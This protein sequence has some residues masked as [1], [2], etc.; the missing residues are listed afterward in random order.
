MSKST[1]TPELLEAI[2]ARVPEG[3]LSRSK[4][5]RKYKLTSKDQIETLTNGSVVNVENNLFYDT[6]RLDAEQVKSLNDW[7]RP[8][9]PLLD[10][11]TH[12]NGATIAERRSA[13]QDWINQ[14]VNAQVPALFAALT[15]QQGYFPVDEASSLFGEALIGYLLQTQWLSQYQSLIYDPLS[16][17]ESTIQ[18]VEH[19]YQLMPLYNELTHYLEQKKGMTASYDELSQKFDED[20]LN[21]VLNMGGMDQF[22]VPL[23]VKPYRS[24]WIYLTLT[25][26]Q[27]AQTV[28]RA[29]VKIKDDAWADALEHSGDVVRPGARDGKT[30]RI[31]VVARTY[32]LNNAAQRLGIGTST[33]E[34]A[35]KRG[36]LSSFIDPEERV[37]IPASEIERA[38]DNP[39]A[40]EQ[41]RG[42]EKVKPREIALVAGISYSTVRRRLQRA[43]IKASGLRWE[44]VR[45]RWGLPERLDEFR[46]ILDDRLTEQRVLRDATR[47]EQERIEAERRER[48]RIAAEQENARRNELRARLVAAFPTWQHENRTYQQIVLHVG[49]PNSGKTHDA[50]NRLS[51]AEDGWYLAPLRLLA[52]EVF[53]RLNR[54]GVLCNLLTGEE[55][56]EIPGA[57]ITAATIEMFNPQNSGECVIIDEAQMLADPD[58]GWAWTRALMEA[59]AP[60]IHVIGPATAQQLI[61]DMAA[62][63]AIPL[64]AV[65]HERLTPIQVAEHNWPLNQL[66]ERTILVAFSRR[67][68][69]GL[70]TE[71]EQQGR[72]VSVV[73]GNLPPEV[74]RRQADRFADGETEICI[75]TDAVGMGLNLPADYVCFYEMQKFDGKQVR[76]LKPSEV[77]Q[78]GGRAGRYGLSTVGEVGAT[79]KRDLHLL[80]KLFYSEPATLTKARVAP[81]VNDLEM[82]PGSLASRLKQWAAL[83]SIPDTLRKVI[84]TSD[85][86]ERIELANMLT[87][88]EVRQLGLEQA[89]RLVNAPTRQSTRPYWRL[90]AQS[91]LNDRAMPLPP[92]PPDKILT[93][94]DLEDSEHSI[95][96][97]DIYLW[98]SQRPEFEAYAPDEPAVREIREEWSRTIDLALLRRL[99]TSRRCSQCGEPLPMNFPYGICDNCH[100]GRTA[101]R[102]SDY[103]DL[104]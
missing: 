11:P 77:Q 102:Q 64:E 14:Q 61:T 93:S 91:I 58:R 104:Y 23:K 2:I 15:E 22:I 4:L 8:A 69:L 94:S 55:Y 34:A 30:R 52:F 53:D 37:R 76:D 57:K 84:E 88:D 41:L 5:A 12:V 42:F 33:L 87:D 71:L 39:D 97:A 20:M 25:D 60:D 18:S 16:L 28:A 40:I 21:S 79:R 51:T 103:F 45:G 95:A 86:E 81:T 26:R 19:R 65:P 63:A 96:A 1:L 7:C 50:L 85:L 32:T 24:R 10:D 70:K 82:I 89:V 83:E 38:Y 54:R 100:Y 56:I 3:F 13:R 67:M 6:Q 98:L 31:R 62:A 27:T 99:D 47:A 73:Y 59:Q 90:C 68:V 46:Q 49:P 72:T 9:L 66:P 43:N 78:I 80:R 48:E 29:A 17:S 101:K 92:L 74:R 35:V 36:M 75:A 44:R